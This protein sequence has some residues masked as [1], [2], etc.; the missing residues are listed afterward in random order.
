LEED[1]LDAVPKSKKTKN[2]GYLKDGFVVDDDENGDD[3]DDMSDSSDES[4][5]D[6]GD[7]GDANGCTDGDDG[8]ILEDI[9]SELSE[10]NYD[11]SD[12]EPLKQ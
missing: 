7:D 5:D 1:D 11:Y 2:G 12:S 4:D 8:L 10:D 3:E 9:G 6:T